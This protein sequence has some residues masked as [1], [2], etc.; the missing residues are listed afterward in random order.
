[1]RILSNL[2][3]SKIR[4]VLL[5]VAPVFLAFLVTWVIA[6][7]DD[8]PKQRV[9]IEAQEPMFTTL[10]ELVNAADLVVV[11]RA[12]QV[13]DGRTVAA[14]SAARTAIRTQLVALEV[15]DVLDG[16]TEKH[17][18]LEQEHALADG[19]PIIV[20]GTPPLVVGD[21]ALL[22]LVKSAD[23]SAPYVALLNSQSRYLVSGAQRDQLSSS[24]SDA[25]SKQLAAMGPYQLRC[26]VMQAGTTNSICSAY[27]GSS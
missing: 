10:Q 14:G 9:D 6:N 27:E 26:A 24:G 4:R 16:S 17:L 12:T 8:G 1:M 19:T 7:Q 15:G 21:E 2:G 11:A 22:F 23:E 13:S 25:L 5:F 20:N 3:A 18:V